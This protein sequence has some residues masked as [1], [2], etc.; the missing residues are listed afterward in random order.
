MR[1]LFQSAEGVVQSTPYLDCAP[2]LTM[3]FYLAGMRAKSQYFAFHIVD[4]GSALQPSVVT[5]FTTGALGIDVPERTV[6]QRPVDSDPGGI[7]L[8]GILM[9]NVFATDLGGDVVW[10][11]PSML[12]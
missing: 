8:H 9:A 12:S 5:S 3:N 4:T 1:V 6:L 2:G 10:Y 11:Y 7:L